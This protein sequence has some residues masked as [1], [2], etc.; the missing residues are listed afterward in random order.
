[1]DPYTGA[2]RYR[3]SAGSAA[4][5][6]MPI[7]SREHLDMSPPRLLH[8]LLPCRRRTEILSQVLRDTLVQRLC[9][10][11]PRKF[12]PF[13]NLSTSNKQML[14]PCGESSFSLTK[15]FDMRLSDCLTLQYPNCRCGGNFYISIINYCITTQCIASDDTAQI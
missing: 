9:K 14:R 12:F 3:S 6:M 13:Q 11:C 8:L 5:N 1:V 7:L 10:Q 4:G 15:P 2:S